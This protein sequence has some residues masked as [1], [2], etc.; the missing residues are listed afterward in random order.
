MVVELWLTKGN[1]VLYCKIQQ[2]Y[3]LSVAEFPRAKLNDATTVGERGVVGDYTLTL[4]ALPLD[5]SQ[6]ASPSQI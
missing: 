3:L 4:H 5:W 1:W 6:D 2:L